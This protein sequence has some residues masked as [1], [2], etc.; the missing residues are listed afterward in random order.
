MKHGKQ[1]EYDFTAETK[2]DAII[3]R[4]DYLIACI[5]TIIAHEQGDEQ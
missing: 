2:H 5:E 4:L 3:Q 1:K